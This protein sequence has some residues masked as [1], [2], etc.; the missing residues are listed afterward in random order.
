MAWFTLARVL[1]VAAVA[2]AAAVVQ[3]LAS[4]PIPNLA[5]GLLI[6]ALVVA[7]EAR[8][9]ETEVTRMLGALVGCSIGLGLAR[10]IG[11]GLFWANVGDPRVAFMHTLILLVLPYLG[12]VICGN[13]GEWLAPG[14]PQGQVPGARAEGPSNYLSTSGIIDVLTPDRL[15]T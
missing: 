10:A 6:A 15:E 9:R 12:L 4:G 11:A 1:F 3:P 5:F 7:F 2:S 8:L 13:H 14:P